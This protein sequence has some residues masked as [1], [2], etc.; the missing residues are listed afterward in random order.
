MDVRQSS[1]PAV[2]AISRWLH[3]LNARH[4]WDH[5][6]FW[7][8][9]ILRRLPARRGRALDVG[10]GSGA[11]AGALADRFAEV[12]AIDVD[13]T[14]VRS[15]RERLGAWRHVRVE[16]R[17][18]AEVEG[19]FDTITFVAS[20]HHMPLEETLGRAGSLLTPGGRLLV[21]GLARVSSRRDAVYDL[22]SA[23]LNPVM[24]LLK[25][26]RPRRA[27]PDP[28]P[29]PI[30]DPGLSVDEIS[31]IARQTLPGARVRRR[32]FF[33]HTLEWTRP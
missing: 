20:L 2:R 30:K 1:N 16:Q 10:C 27:E 11:L 26:P 17:P 13:P 32:L 28:D 33:R 29:M 9:W 7:H 3:R 24:G 6:A 15:A 31:A 23:V 18:F 22:A 25:H 8:R 4:P 14:M 19:G 21:V 5:N 12:L